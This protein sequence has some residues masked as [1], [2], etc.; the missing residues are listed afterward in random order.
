MKLQVSREQKSF[1]ARNSSSLVEA[2]LTLDA[3]RKV[4]PLGIY[5]GKKPVGFVMIGYDWQIDEAEG[6]ECETPEIAKGN[7]MI[8]RFM[9][10]RRYQNKGYGR[11]ALRLALDYMGFERKQKS[12]S[13]L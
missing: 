7:Y 2:Y 9:I 3:G 13:L 4:F 10:D 8:W 6:D 1:V 12:Y 5:C 11:A